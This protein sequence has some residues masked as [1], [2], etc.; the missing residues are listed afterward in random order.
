[1][2]S[3]NKIISTKFAKT[4]TNT[5][6]Y[7]IKNYVIHITVILPHQ[8]VYLKNVDKKNRNPKPLE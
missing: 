7:K 4:R 2:T 3:K 5:G 8:R 1:M 6:F